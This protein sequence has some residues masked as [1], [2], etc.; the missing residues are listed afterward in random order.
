MKLI[1]YS[2]IAALNVSP[3]TCYQWASEM[4]AKKD[5]ALLPPKIS[6]KPV[7]GTFCNVMPCMIGNPAT[8]GGVKVVT[9]YPDRTPSLDST[10]LLMNAATGEFLALMDGNWVTTMRTGAVAAHSIRLFAKTNYKTLG[11]IGLGNVS[12]AALLVLA[13]TEPDKELHIK[14][15][16]YKGQEQ[17]FMER[18]AAYPQLHFECVD[19]YREAVRGSDVVIS[20]VT[21]APVDFC[22]D[23][24]FD[25]GVLVVPI[26]TLGFTNCDLFFDKIYGDDYGHVC[27]FKN[28]DKFKSFAEVSA[29][30]NNAA[31]GR[32]NDKERILAYNVG[33]STHD[34]YFA[35]Q[36]YQLLKNDPQLTEL[37]L[38][39]PTEKF[40]I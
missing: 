40:W 20:G 23:E 13:E 6:I 16:R 37:S 24:D 2:D 17:S 8:M 9:R 18:F 27:G 21:Y 14:L 33:V 10:I 38:N 39:G 25:E 26:H 30:V 11:I 5:G 35:S 3:A 29:V 12:R 7:S 4:I 32:E 1:T 28:F 36:L 15:L 19:S 34:V 31:P 22:E